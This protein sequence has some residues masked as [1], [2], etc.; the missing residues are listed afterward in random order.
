MRLLTR[1][2]YRAFPELDAFSDEQCKNF[3]YAAGRPWWR[4]LLRWLAVFA[5]ITL[6][7][8]GLGVVISVTQQR[9]GVRWM[10]RGLETLLWLGIAVGLLVPGFVIAM[11][12]R[13][14]LLARRVRRV[15]N[16]RG[17]CH[18]CAYSLLG[19]RV[20][21]DL[22]IICPEC[23]TVAIA[24]ESLN[25]LASTES[26]ERV[27]Q[28]AAPREQPEVRARRRRRR[29]K[30]IKWSAITVG[31]CALVVTITAGLWWSSLKSQAR[32]A[33][34]ARN[35]DARVAQLVAEHQRPEAAGRANDY[36]ALLDIL[37]EVNSFTKAYPQRWMAANPGADNIQ[38]VDFVSLGDSGSEAQYR[39][40]SG[41]TLST[42]RFVA[43]DAVLDA[44]DDGLTQRTRA[45]SEMAR[46]ERGMN[47]PPGKAAVYIGISELGHAR[48]YA[49]WTVARMHVACR[50]HNATEYLAALDE[51]L[52]VA[53]AVDHQGC[54]IDHLLAVAVR[55]L[56]LRTIREQVSADPVARAWA[57][58]TLDVLLRRHSPSLLPLAFKVEKESMLDTVRWT[59]SDP[60]RAARMTLLGDVGDLGNLLSN[61]PGSFPPTLVSYD[62]HERD[63]TAYMDAAI[64][65]LEAGQPIPNTPPRTGLIRLL[66]PSLQRAQGSEAALNLDT[67][68]TFL[69]LALEEHHARTGEYPRDADALGDRLPPGVVVDPAGGL[70]L[71]FTIVPD[72]DRPSGSRPM[73]TSGLIEDNDEAAS[74]DTPPGSAA[75]SQSP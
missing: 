33:A 40:F 60:V 9:V 14:W 3:M 64:A 31:V 47:T 26:G 34:A 45:I 6:T 66:A 28:P 73:I 8:V 72:P 58:R 29:R 10:S 59:F 57:G 38:Y 42:A 44:R 7:L 20:G 48:N 1:K 24:D 55:S 70:H 49:R 46:F 75:P 27:Y 51:A 2:L 53:Q 17:R 19:M 21:A 37:L 41:V 25:E 65:A 23:G 56:L 5:I 35:F 4:R 52:V 74:G 63:A 13:D 15:I 54:L 39:R 50:E 61:T 67:R 16:D 12:T 11:R 32:R 18:R 30:V 62:A 22:R 36:P 71:I 43:R 69:L 68:M